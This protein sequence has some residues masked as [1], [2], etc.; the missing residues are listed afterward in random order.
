L[1]VS[2][3]WTSLS[4]VGSAFQAAGLDARSV[5]F[6]WVRSLRKVV[7]RGAQV[8][9]TVHLTSRLDEF[10]KVDWCPT[11]D[12]RVH[13]NAEFVLHTISDRQPA[14]LPLYGHTAKMNSVYL[15]TALVSNQ[16]P[17][18]LQKTAQCSH[19]LNSR[20]WHSICKPVW[21]FTAPGN[22]GPHRTTPGPYRAGNDWLF[23]FHDELKGVR[24]ADYPQ[25]TK[26]MNC[27]W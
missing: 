24:R 9:A 21:L 16:S 14:M 5:N 2:L 13:Q 19:R 1:K 15:N 22:T 3:H 8:R 10:P 11:I 27:N 7:V 25:L 20:N 12:D 17:I 6:V 18:S 26:E 4:S 23:H